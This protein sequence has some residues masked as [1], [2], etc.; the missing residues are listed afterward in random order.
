MTYSGPYSRA[1]IKAMAILVPLSQITGA[2]PVWG[3]WCVEGGG[4]STCTKTT[5]S[6]SGNAGRCTPTM[7]T[8]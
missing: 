6:G 4:K 3:P 7:I 8:M 5:R 2:G 1:A